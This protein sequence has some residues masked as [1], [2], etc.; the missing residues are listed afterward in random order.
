[1]RKYTYQKDR[2]KRKD[3]VNFLTAFAICIIAIGLALGS[4]YVSI[5]G[6]SEN[7]RETYVSVSTDAT[8]A[9]SNSVTGVTVYNETTVVSEATE[10]VTQSTEET[11]PG[12]NME[13]Y[14]GSSEGLQTIL[15]VM[16]SLDFPVP[17]GKI[18]RMYSDEA[19]YNETMGDYRPH[20][21]VDFA[22]EADENVI[23]MT[24]GVVESIRQ[25]EM[26][27]NVIKITEGNIS[28]FYCGVSD[29]M[30]CTDGARVSRGDIIAKVGTVPCEAEDESHLHVEVWV[31]DKTIDPLAVISNNE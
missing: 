29:I 28:V 31:G 3:K 1:M 22:A 23:A 19:V 10:I 24:D 21:G 30:Y 9:V 16:K 8:G 18:M 27:G 15:Q 14:T 17:S 25:D 6:F 26:Y 5:G 12:D 11:I 7:T 4:T 13:P 2:K 20:T